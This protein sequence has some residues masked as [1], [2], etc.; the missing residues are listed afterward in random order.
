LLGFRL[1]IRDVS[2]DFI[3]STADELDCWVSSFRRLSILEEVRQD[4]DFADKIGEG[5]YAFVCKAIDNETGQVV[6]VKRISKEKISRS[7]QGVKVLGNEISCMRLLNHP[8]ILK[9]ER[10]YED[11]EFVYL[12]LE[13]AEGGDLFERLSSKEVF[14]EQLCAVLARNLLRPL[15]YMHK[16]EIMHRDL[17]LENILMASDDDE[18][19]I[20][21]ADFGFACKM[22]PEN[23][24][25]NCG[26]PGYFAPEVAH[27]QPYGAKADVFS[28]G[29][30]LYSLLTGKPPF[31][32]RTVEE[33]LARNRKGTINF[34]AQ[35]WENISNDAQD[36]VRLLTELYV[37]DRPSAS[38]ALGHAWLQQH[39]Q[40][41]SI[42]RPSFSR[43][44]SD[45]ASS[46]KGPLEALR[47]TREGQ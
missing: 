45:K 1:R 15:A 8:N 40:T 7:F 19:R 26:T 5:S 13:F 46:I 32:G 25:M 37:D 35:D 14:T 41:I 11:T 22:T 44:V 47:C 9:L 16:H 34:E 28:V 27:K 4:Y 30:I 12:V 36:L 18:T 3:V 6:A 39:D 43:R 10:V 38:E 24:S 29:V 2:Q 31:Y 17:K 42:I 20:K 21:I 23:L 33:I